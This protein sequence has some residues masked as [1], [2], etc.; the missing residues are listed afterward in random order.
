[1]WRVY[2]TCYELIGPSFTTPAVKRRP[3]YMSNILKAIGHRVFGRW[4]YPT[5]PS[6][7]LCETSNSAQ[8]RVDPDGQ[9]V[10]HCIFI[11]RR[12]SGVALTLTISHS[13]H[14]PPFTSADG[15]LTLTWNND[16][17]ITSFRSFRGVIGEGG[18]HISLPRGVHISGAIEGGPHEVQTFVGTGSWLAS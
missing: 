1:M 9:S 4:F 14:I 11:F 10:G 13:L 5:L 16:E 2:N 15:A 7:P 3:L 18:V 6:S 12:R 17:D 8:G